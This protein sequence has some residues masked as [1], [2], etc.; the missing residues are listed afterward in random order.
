MRMNRRA[1]GIAAAW[2]LV[3]AAAALQTIV[4]ARATGV[5]DVGAALARRL[6]ILP[7][8]MVATPLVLWSARRHPPL[9]GS[10][11]P[12]VPNVLLHLA[13]GVAFVVVA[14]ALIRVPLALDRGGAA[15]MRSTVAGL[16]EYL[17]A[18]LL[19][20]LVIVAAGHLSAA[21]SVST[22]EPPAGDTPL[23]CLAVRQ[24]DRVH[25]V[26]LA[27][28]EWIEAEGNYVVVH[29]NGK[30]Y[31]G[32]ERI[33]DI[34]QRL[35]DRRFVRIHRSTIVPVA[36]VREVQPLNHGDHAVILRGGKVLR[37]AR[38]RREVLQ[39]AIAVVLP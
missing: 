13:L 35:D 26:R 39:K 37:V 6:S 12:I 10:R 23:D 4:L 5:A 34:E 14:N 18:A 2:L 30:R 24:W 27:E 36:N 20:Y 7:L 33:G 22:A 31:R 17:P 3:A 16:A 32:R 1:L 9:D 38:S 28:I 11:R 21:A 8:W 19:V 15:F 25:L 29:A